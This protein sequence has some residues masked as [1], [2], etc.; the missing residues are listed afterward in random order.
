MREW[1]NRAAWKAAPRKGLVGSN[2]TLSAQFLSFMYFVYVI[3]S[4]R[5]NWIYIGFT[6]DLRKRFQEHNLGKVRVTKGNRP[7]IL[8]YYEAYR[9]EFDARK[10]E[11]ELKTKGQQKEF[12]KKRI[13]N[14]LEIVGSRP[15]VDQ[16]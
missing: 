7:F 12:L 5:K 11:I 3:R 16:P 6:S 15:T 14:S 13:K 2:P 9:N 4:S 10:R 8:A 1:L